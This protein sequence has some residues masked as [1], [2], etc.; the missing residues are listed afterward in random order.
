MN[1]DTVSES[2]VTI[3]R[4]P[5]PN[6]AKRLLNSGKITQQEYDA[7][8][9]G[10]T[11]FYVSGSDQDVDNIPYV[12]LSKTSVDLCDLSGPFVVPASVPVPVSTTDMVREITGNKTRAASSDH[13]PVSGNMSPA[14]VLSHLL[15]S[16]LLESHADRRR[17]QAERRAAYTHSKQEHR[18]QIES[19]K[20]HKTITK[21]LEKWKTKI[22]PRWEELQHTAEVYKLIQ[23]GIPTNMRGD[24]WL[25]LVGNS[26]KITEDE[27]LACV[28]EAELYQSAHNQ[29]N[30]P[31]DNPMH[32]TSVPLDET[33][34]TQLCTSVHS[35]DNSDMINSASRGD[36]QHRNSSTSVNSKNQDSPDSNVDSVCRVES[37]THSAAGDH[38]ISNVS[39]V[40][41]VVDE[42]VTSESIVE[43]NSGTE[44]QSCHATSAVQGDQPAFHGNAEQHTERESYVAPLSSQ[45]RD[46]AGRSSLRIS[47]RGSTLSSE[48]IENQHAT[49]LL[50]EWDLPR[51]FPTLSFFHDGGPM[52]QALDRVLKAYA[53]YRPDVGYVQ[54]MSYVVAVFLLYMEEYDAFVCLS[55]LL[56]KNRTNI[57]FY[58]LQKPAI[59]YYVNCFDFFF[60]QYLPLLHEHFIGEGISSEM[61][62][63]DWYLTVFSKALPL[64]VAARMWDIYLYQGEVF[65]LRASLGLLR[66]FAP[67][68]SSWSLEKIL[69]FL[70]HIPEEELNVEDL[71]TNIAQIK[72]AEQKYAQVKKQF[73]KRDTTVNSTRPQA[74]NKMTRRSR[75]SRDR[76]RS[77]SGRSIPTDEST[78]SLS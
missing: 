29:P 21:N 68:L 49:M 67:R 43:E 71:M 2:N 44:T 60:S 26:L 24:I 47:C 23:S 48:A 8:I 72:V 22:L 7:I 6:K 74:T 53:C 51:T 11:E 38:Y 66:L 1:Q 37:P 57:D 54:G 58:K 64:E 25:R 70:A 69:P 34:D 73:D 52:A 39:E 41:T 31:H 78:C 50:I 75:L 45:S 56:N 12:R 59:N 18:R 35:E 62:L 76:I 36:F 63:L 5:V 33:V 15:P 32:D 55:N 4:S 17:I 28:E 16:T 40:A 13:N 46:S 3:Q 65:I 19:L 14:S 42:V 20:R 9:S 61:F 27:Y 10:D 30:P 77:H